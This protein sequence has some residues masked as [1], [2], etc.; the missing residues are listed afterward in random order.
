MKYNVSVDVPVP[1]R[2]GIEL[3][4]NVWL[5][6]TGGPVPVLLVRNPYGKHVLQNYG[7]ARTTRVAHVAYRPPSRP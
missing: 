6:G 7:R 3:A 2:D 4:A 5:P 1:M